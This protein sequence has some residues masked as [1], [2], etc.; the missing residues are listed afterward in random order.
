M[1]CD[2]ANACEQQPRTSGEPPGDANVRAAVE[3]LA[4]SRQL[5]T[6]L[7]LV[8][9]LRYVVER[10]LTGHA[11]RIKSYTIA[12]E[13]LGRD[14]NFDPGADPI[15]RVE[16]GRLRRALA[17]YYA[18]PGRDDPVV[19]ELPR[20]SYVPLFRLPDAATRSLGEDREAVVDVPELLSALRRRLEAM[21]TEIEIAKTMLERSDPAPRRRIDAVGLPLSGPAATNRAIR[22]A[23]R[24]ADG[25][26]ARK[27]Q[28]AQGAL[29]A[30]TC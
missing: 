29:A 12:V 30:R 4:T 1:I 23:E 17:H 26:Q 27:V 22:E 11:D 10:A 20:G 2:V 28:Q 19:I 7:R 6:S 8:A 25:R 13:A 18:G 14:A 16:A 15:V 9:F 24:M 21:A 3:R 5:R